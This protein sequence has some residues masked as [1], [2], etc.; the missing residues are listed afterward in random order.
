MSREVTAEE[1]Q[2]KLD[3]IERDYHKKRIFNI[4]KQGYYEYLSTNL[5]CCFD[6]DNLSEQ[7]G[8]QIDSYVALA[9]EHEEKADLLYDLQGEHFGSSFSSRTDRDAYE[10]GEKAAKELIEIWK[11]DVNPLNRQMATGEEE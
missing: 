8:K 10:E 1:L 9:V 2:D 3:E 11:K 6:N 4:G 5:H 7:A